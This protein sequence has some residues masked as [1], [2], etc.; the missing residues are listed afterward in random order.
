MLIDNVLTVKPSNKDLAFLPFHYY[1]NIIPCPMP[2]A[3]VIVEAHLRIRQL[4]A[5][6]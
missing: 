6:A 1:Y 2:H 4:L 5:V 3:L